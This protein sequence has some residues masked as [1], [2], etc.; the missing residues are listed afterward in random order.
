M[1]WTATVTDDL[2][3]PDESSFGER[4]L[5]NSDILALPA[6]GCLY[7]VRRRYLAFKVANKRW[8]LSHSLTHTT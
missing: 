8:K 2:F 3:I 7:L 6:R 5:L 4:K 1:P